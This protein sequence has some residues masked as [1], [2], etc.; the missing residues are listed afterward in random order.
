MKRTTLLFILFISSSILLRSNVVPSRYSISGSVGDESGNPLSGATIIL[1]GT[2]LG[3]SSGL[4]GTFILR[5]I[6]EGIYN[7]KVSYLGYA[8]VVK[9]I[10]LW[11]DVTL[12]I[13]LTP[14]SIVADEIIVKG[15]R[16]SSETPVAFTELN[17]ELIRKLNTGQDI[18]Y[19][20]SRVPSLVETSEAGTGIGYTNFRIRGTDPSRINV[21]IDGIP[22][23]DAES[24]QVF[25]V[26]MPDLA[27]SVDDIQVQRG[28]GTST[29]GAAA[30]GASVNL[31]TVNPS[32][33]AYAE[34]STSYG[35]FNTFKGS[36]KAGTG[37][38]KEKFVM[39]IRISGL[40]SDGYIQRS[41]SSHRS[42]FMT[43]AYKLTKG[44]L[45]VNFIHG[46]EV[47]GISWWGVPADSL[48]ANRTYNPAG[49]YVNSFGL[50]EHYHSQ[51][52]NYT[53]THFQLIYNWQFNKN[54]YLNI[55]A[56]F[57]RGLGYYEQYR[58]DDDLSDYGLSSWVYAGLIEIKSTDL[59]RRKWMFNYFGGMVY[60]LHYNKNRLEAD[61]GGGFNRYLGDHFGRI[62]WMRHAGTTE[63]DFLWHTNGALKDDFNIFGKINFQMTEK[64]NLFTDLQY[65]YI[66]YSMNGDDDDLRE[67]NLNK[68]YH[69]INP[70]AGLF[71]RFSARHEAYTSFSV[72]NRE[73]TRANFKDAAGDPAAMP[74]PECLL[75]LESGYR[76]KSALSNLGINLYYMIYKD[77]LVPTGELSNVGYPIMTNVEKSHRAGIELLAGIKPFRMLEW[78][79]SLTL[80]KN[81]IRDH[82]EYYTDYENFTGEL[83]YL[84]KFLGDVDIAYSPSVIA[85]N[86]FSVYPARNL[87]IHII[88]KYVGKQYFDNTASDLR[89]I[90][91]YLVSNLR[92]DYSFSLKMIERIDLQLQVNNLLNNMYLSNG[93]GGYW[94]EDGEEHNWAYY[95]P[96]AGIN[97]ITRLTIRF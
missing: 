2:Y 53:Q 73:P 61:L 21:T 65:R 22:L 50:L 79:A 23:N 10:E 20:L 78:N 90:D 52:D 11:S 64:L 81:K 94:Y 24:Q 62:I 70:K 57:T 33:E 35:S 88:S 19:L 14:T 91:P 39:D 96:Q 54:L 4:N 86:E 56:H 29:N 30:F 89:K 25:W 6:P 36:L 95:F 87:A 38:L 59:V 13:T 58:E 8:T 77:Q 85:S 7:L 71:Y 47:T 97:Y 83:F 17:S 28:V 32:E 66:Y 3:T 37:L 55:A 9:E 63:K 75:D 74:R 80:S 1:E 16:A 42:L 41:G 15:V 60:N 72:A 12:D 18:P 69:F 82:T 31:K 68:K 67:L 51:E 45:K 26:D 93:Y 48:A 76:Y 92:L 40:M 34:V 5:K 44:R 46:E 27:G 84:S 43:S 49:K